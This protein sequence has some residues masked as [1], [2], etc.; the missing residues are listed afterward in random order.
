MALGLMPSA[1]TCYSI[2]SVPHSVFFIG[3]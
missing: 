3:I 2:S 1:K